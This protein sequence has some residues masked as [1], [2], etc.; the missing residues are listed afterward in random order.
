MS[1]PKVAF[2]GPKCGLAA[3]YVFAEPASS[4]RVEVIGNVTALCLADPRPERADLCPDF[5]SE[6]DRIQLFRDRGYFP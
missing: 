4:T 5:R 2:L 6:M 1:A 3:R